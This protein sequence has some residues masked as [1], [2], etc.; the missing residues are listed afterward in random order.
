MAIVIRSSEYSLEE[1]HISF[2]F[3]LWT[4]ICAGA[5]L[6]T[7]LVVATSL[8]IFVVKV[9]PLVETVAENTQTVFAGIDFQELNIAVKRLVKILD[10]VCLSGFIHCD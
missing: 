5:T 10:E 4:K 6:M 1:D 9:V 8:S 3:P 2:T 7:S